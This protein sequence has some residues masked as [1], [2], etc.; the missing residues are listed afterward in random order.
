MQKVYFCDLGL[1]NQ[2]ERNFNEITFRA[3]NG[4]IFENG[5]ML[6]LWRNKG[7]GGDLQFY[8]TADGMEVDFV[9]SRF[10]GKIAVE[11]KFKMLQ[12]PISL[13]GFNNFCIEEDINRKYIINQNLN[14]IRNE[15]KLIQGFLTDKIR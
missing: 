10:T 13:Q 1:R 4:A 6:S 5:V 8:R 14:S 7:A 9:M 11:C 3:D 2:I 12:K 15:T